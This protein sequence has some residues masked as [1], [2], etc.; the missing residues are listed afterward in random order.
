VEAVAA[1][2]S[3]AQRARQG[4]ACRDGRHGAMEGMVRWKAVSKQPTWSSPGRACATA[5]ITARLCGWCSGAS[6]TS[7]SSA[8]KTSSSRRTGSLKRSPPCTTRWPTAATVSAP[9]C[10]STQRSNAPRTSSCVV[11]GKA[12]TSSGLP[13]GPVADRRGWAPM[14]STSPRSAADS[15]R[16]NSANFRLLDPAFSV[17]TACATGLARLIHRHGCDSLAGVA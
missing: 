7:S 13:P 6:G 11:P 16:W 3:L 8:A 1:D 9:R 14:P 17:S 10:S 4:E 2:S 15:S 12:G 5:R